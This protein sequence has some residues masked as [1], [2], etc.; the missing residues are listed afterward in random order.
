MLIRLPPLAVVKGLM[1][2]EYHS[3]EMDVPLRGVTLSDSTLE[4]MLEILRI[5][6][7]SFAASAAKAR[8]RNPTTNAIAIFSTR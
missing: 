2:E 5:S 4:Q 7:I 1:R 3:S 6:L 8:T